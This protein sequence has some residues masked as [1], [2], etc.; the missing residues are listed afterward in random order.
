MQLESWPGSWPQP[1]PDKRY[2]LYIHV[3]FCES[4]CPFCSFH[5]VRMNKERAHQYFT[6]LNRQLHACKS[7][8]FSFSDVY[9][10]GGTPTVLPEALAGT[11]ELTRELF[12]VSGISVETN[13]NHLQPRILDLLQSAGVTR[14]SVGVQSLDDRLLQ[15]MERFAP[16]GSSA[17]ILQHLQVAQG[18]FATLNV[19]LIFNFPHQSFSSISRDL[20]LLTALGVDQI[21]CYP[22]MPS[23]T[24]HHTMDRQIGHVGFAREREYYERI[25]D[26]L[27][28]DYQP[29]S[30]WCFSRKAGAI[31][32]YIVDHDEYLG[33]GSGA[34]TYLDGSIYSSTFSINHYLDLA[35][36]G[37]SAL[38]AARKLNRREQ[39]QYDFLMRLFG[40]R[41]DKT[42]M[43]AKYGPGW[44]RC[45]RRELLLFRWLGALH[46][47]GTEVRLGREGMYYW[48][49]MMRELFIGVNNFRA[50]MRGQIRSELEDYPVKVE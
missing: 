34:F 47:S 25:R 3:P 35:G 29:G 11:L 42:A 49:L 41:M 31:D 33:I 22:L 18:R 10:G 48:V 38:T 24:T 30:A 15:E 23:D 28:P 26:I 39:V 6:A 20:R 46:E 40:M 32:E 50:Q 21:S 13:P 7:A 19:D 12:N 5:R 45:V 37:Q 36:Q 8:G 4:L 2:L 27:M 1:D 14:L 16:Y 43:A 44:R 17:N 9:V